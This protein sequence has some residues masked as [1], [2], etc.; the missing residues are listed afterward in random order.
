[1]K[2]NKTGITLCLVFLFNFL[3]TKQFFKVSVCARS[4]FLKLLIKEF[5][6]LSCSVFTKKTAEENLI[7]VRNAC[8]K[9]IVKDTRV[10]H[11][12]FLVVMS[13]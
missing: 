9:S 2:F 12:M 5:I 8:S 4:L 3:C 6:S 11:V 10:M 13:L 1:M 7:Q